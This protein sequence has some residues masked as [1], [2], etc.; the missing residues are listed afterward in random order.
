MPVDFEEERKR[1]RETRG[2]G[3]GAGKE[4]VRNRFWG[5]EWGHRKEKGDGIRLILPYRLADQVIVYAV[6]GH[7]NDTTM[8]STAKPILYFSSVTAEIKC[9]ADRAQTATPASL[10]PHPQG[11]REGPQTVLKSSFLKHGLELGLRIK[12]NCLKHRQHD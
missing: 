5:G 1:G 8:Q 12:I 10:L 4:R 7:E 11:T 2:R 6:S 9:K 3:R